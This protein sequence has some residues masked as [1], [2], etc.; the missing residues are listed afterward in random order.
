MEFHDTRSIQEAVVTVTYM[1]LHHGVVS[2]AP[3]L[4]VLQA[5]QH[6]RVMLVTFVG[7][8]VTD[9]GNVQRGTGPQPHAVAVVGSVITCLNFQWTRLGL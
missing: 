8:L 3:T 6:P 7:V 5:K 2:S 9:H 4:C 1:D